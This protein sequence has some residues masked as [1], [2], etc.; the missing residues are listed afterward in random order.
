MTVQTSDWE[1]GQRRGPNRLL[2]G[3]IVVALAVGGCV[4]LGAMVFTSPGFRAVSE[5]Y[6][7]S[8]SIV[9]SAH[10]SV[11]NG[12]P[13]RI[14]ITVARDVSRAEALRFECERVVPVLVREHVNAE[15]WIYHPDGD[16]VLQNA[17]CR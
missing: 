13:D 14:T 8:K 3:L 9:N 16:Y 2:L 11:V 17:P 1:R 7:N 6:A 15:I 12:R 4:A 10:Y 5:I